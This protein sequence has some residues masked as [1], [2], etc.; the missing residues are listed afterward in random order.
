MLWKHDLRHFH[1]WWRSDGLWDRLLWLPQPLGT[2]DDGLP[3]VKMP[4]VDDGMLC[5]MQCW[6]YVFWRFGVISSIKRDIFC[7]KPHH[8]DSRSY[9]ITWGRF[10]SRHIMV[11]HVWCLFKSWSMHV[12]IMG[13]L[14]KN[15]SQKTPKPYEIWSLQW[16]QITASM[17]KTPL[18]ISK[19]KNWIECI[20]ICASKRP[21]DSAKAMGKN[22]GY[23]QGQK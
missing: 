12:Q 21:I 22:K 23:T 14:R 6:V 20:K 16:T 5:V 9:H 3:I 13:F 2:R 15:D 10:G 18:E 8:V 17:A 7:K 19:T 4:M 1:D 11:G